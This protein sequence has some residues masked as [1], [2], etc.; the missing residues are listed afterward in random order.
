MNRLATAVLLL[1]KIEKIDEPNYTLEEFTKLLDKVNIEYSVIKENEMSKLTL[2]FDEDLSYVF[3]LH[4]HYRISLYK[5]YSRL[6]SKLSEYYN[7]LDVEKN[8]KLMTKNMFLLMVEELLIGKEEQIGINELIVRQSSQHYH[9]DGFVA[10]LMFLKHFGMDACKKISYVEVVD[11]AVTLD[12]SKEAMKLDFYDWDMN[13]M[14][15]ADYH[16]LKIE[17][18]LVEKVIDVY[19]YQLSITE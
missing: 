10:L 16:S 9:E 12:E 13:L 19:N 5:L 18:N 3:A 8:M 2:D 7:E 11:S 1:R 17:D 6:V 14:L 15:T 4:N